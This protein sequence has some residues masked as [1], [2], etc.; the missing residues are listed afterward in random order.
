MAVRSVHQIR[1]IVLADDPRV[2]RALAGLLMAG[3][4]VQVVEDPEV[5]GRWDHLPRRRSSDVAVVDLDGA[6]EATGL[7]AIARLRAG[8]PTSVVVAVGT[9]PSLE[10][11]ALA[12]GADAFVSKHAPPRAVCEA[13]DRLIRSKSAALRGRGQGVRPT[14]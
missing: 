7:D 14:R 1:A 11:P 2:R 3:G 12:A 4:Q 13:V 6:G 9:A 8:P 5:S 10:A